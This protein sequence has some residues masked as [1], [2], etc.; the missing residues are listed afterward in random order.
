[1]CHWCGQ[2]YVVTPELLRAMNAEPAEAN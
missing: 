1:V 2:R